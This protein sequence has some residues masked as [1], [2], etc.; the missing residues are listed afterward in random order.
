MLAQPRVSLE[1]YLRVKDLPL[2]N[3]QVKATTP[4]GTFVALFSPTSRKQIPSA[5]GHICDRE[6]DQSAIV[7]TSDHTDILHNPKKKTICFIKVVK[8]MIPGLLLNESQPRV[9]PQIKCGR[10][11]DHSR[12]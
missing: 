12:G 11:N 7:G 1:I 9:A 6:T 4:V 3:Q 10:P 5:F 8:V 2:V